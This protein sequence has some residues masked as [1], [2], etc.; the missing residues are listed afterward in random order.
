LYLLVTLQKVMFLL[1]LLLGDSLLLKV[2]LLKISLLLYKKHMA[3]IS[4]A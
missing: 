4:L 3:M 2:E 1:L